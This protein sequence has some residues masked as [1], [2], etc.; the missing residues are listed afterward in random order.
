L[1]LPLLVNRLL[2]EFFNL[3]PNVQPEPVGEDRL[4]N[5]VE[6][7]LDSEIRLGHVV[8]LDMVAVRLTPPERFVVVGTP[9]FFRR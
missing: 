2:P 7:A 6:E 1:S 4:I 8:R 5:I 3:Y 9:D